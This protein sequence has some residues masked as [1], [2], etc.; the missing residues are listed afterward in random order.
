MEKLKHFLLDDDLAI[1][2]FVE[3]ENADQPRDRSPE[4]KSARRMILVRAT[5]GEF[6]ATFL[7]FFSVCGIYLNSNRDNKF[8]PIP[9]FPAIGCV[10]TGFAAVAIIY[11]F[12]D[13]SGAHFNPAVTFA[14]WLT[15]KTSNRKFLLFVLSQLLGGI[16]L[17]C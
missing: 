15:K 4:A 3:P 7:F 13:I 8:N 12:A 11:S 9:S 16:F 5:L 17:V 1:Q 10:G 2:Q 6:L 14:C